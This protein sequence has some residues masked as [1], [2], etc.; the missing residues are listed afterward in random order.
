MFLVPFSKISYMHILVI[1]ASVYL[2][3]LI[4]VSLFCV[5]IF[6][7]VL[8]CF[9]YYIFIYSWAYESTI[10]HPGIQLIRNQQYIFFLSFSSVQLFSHVRLCDLMD[11][12]RPGFPVPHHSQSLLRLI[13]IESVMPS[14]HPSSVVPFFS[15]L[16]S[17]PAS[18]SFQMSQFFTSGGQSIEVSASASVLPMNI[19]D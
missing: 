11:C 5:S 14:N 10:S 2:W 17:F 12:S 19:Q 6:M 13:S 1:H 16:Q 7:P 8:Y 15:C 4:S 9:D 18:G 3:G